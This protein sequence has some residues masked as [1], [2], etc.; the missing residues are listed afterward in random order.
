[1]ISRSEADVRTWYH[2]LGVYC[3]RTLDFRSFSTFSIL[4]FS[5]GL[6]SIVENSHIIDLVMVLLLLLSLL[7]SLCFFVVNAPLGV[8]WWQSDRNIAKQ[9][10]HTWDW[11]QFYQRAQRVT[12]TLYIMWWC[13]FSFVYRVIFIVISH[14]NCFQALFFQFIC[15]PHY[16]FVLS[17]LLNWSDCVIVCLDTFSHTL[18]WLVW[19]VHLLAF[20][21][22]RIKKGQYTYKVIYMYSLI[23]CISFPCVLSESLAISETHLLSAPLLSKAFSWSQLLFF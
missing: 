12:D 2:L 18:W 22:N 7:L 6:R 23:I 15:V 13:H 21:L 11:K 5:C 4:S 17:L 14:K 20:R 1:M 10:K 3:A 19:C 8:W 9:R 16:C